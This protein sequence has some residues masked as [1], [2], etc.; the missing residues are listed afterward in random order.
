VSPTLIPLGLQVCEIRP[1]RT[2]R[3]SVSSCGLVADRYEDG[4]ADV[5]WD[6]A[7][8]AITARTTHARAQRASTMGVSMDGLLR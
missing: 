5:L 4:A 3:G 7:W 8:V 1:Q 2:L 6:A